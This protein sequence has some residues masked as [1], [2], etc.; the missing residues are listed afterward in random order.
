MEYQAGARRV[1][2]P[3]TKGYQG[4]VGLLCIIL[5]LIRSTREY[6][7]AIHKALRR[8]VR[9][10]VISKAK[11]PAHIQVIDM[12]IPDPDSNRHVS[13]RISLLRRL[14]KG[15]RRVTGQH[16]GQTRFMQE[17]VPVVYKSQMTEA[18]H[19][20]ISVEIWVI[21]KLALA[22]SDGSTPSLSTKTDSKIETPLP[23][24]HSTL[25]NHSFS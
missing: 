11:T 1:P 3:T 6:N 22:S 15:G 4:R 21:L 14:L 17:D 23:F 13:S 16:P 5:V 24:V 25:W 18:R 8:I 10:L 12:T 7:Q 19:T 9:G 2:S 20:C